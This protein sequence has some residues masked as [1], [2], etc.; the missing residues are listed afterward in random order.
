LPPNRSAATEPQGQRWVN[1][2]P[3]LD[4]FGPYADAERLATEAGLRRPQ[5]SPSS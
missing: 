5:P 3:V 1:W 2:L 4:Q